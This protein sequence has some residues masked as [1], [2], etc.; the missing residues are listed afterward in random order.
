[1]AE[2]EAQT[3]FISLKGQYIK[4]L[5]FENPRAPESLMSLTEA[6]GIEV[7]VD[8]AAQRLQEN[9]FELAIRIQAKAKQ[10]NQTLFLADLTYA[11]IFE[12]NAKDE[13]HFEPL[14][15]IDC[16]HI[17]FPFARRVVSDVTRDGGFP[18]LQVEPIN[19]AGLYEQ[20]K[21]NIQ[22]GAPEAD[23]A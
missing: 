2:S 22:R 10:E 15:L 17:L 6:P 8:L 12:V 14:V 13:A 7:N 19:F 3:P 1:M 18:P 21:G 11:G 16:A 5:S 9:V 20:N 23:G 4:D